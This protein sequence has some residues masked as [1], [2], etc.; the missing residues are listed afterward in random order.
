MEMNKIYC[1][2]VLEGLKQIEDETIDLIITSPPYNMKTN[3]GGSLEQKGEYFWNKLNN[4]Y[5]NYGDDMPYEDYVQWQR[6]VLTECMRVLKKTGAMFY[7]H[8]FRI[9]N[10]KL[11]TRMEIVE[12]FP[13]RQIIIWNKCCS[14]NFNLSHIPP[15]YEVIFVLAKDDFRFNDKGGWTD[16]WDIPPERNNIHP[17]PFPLEIPKKILQ[18]TDA[19]LILDI[20]AGSGTTAL[21]CIQENRNF[22]GFEISEEYCKIANERIKKELAQNKLGFLLQ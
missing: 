20:F 11:L 1:I 10:N 7:N 9:Q 21:A 14:F 16:V 6:K 15:S 18:K 19:K 2:D 3:V 13:L 8:K 4:G 5:D 17:A 22:I 12:G